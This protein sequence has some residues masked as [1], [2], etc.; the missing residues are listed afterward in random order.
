MFVPSYQ[1]RNVLNVYCKQLRHNLTSEKNKKEPAKPPVDQVKLTPEAKR[2]ATIDKVSKEIVDKITRFDS[3][4]KMHD[5]L[6]ERAKGEQPRETEPNEGKDTT[7][8]FNVIDTINE[9]IT[10]KL[11]VEGSGFSVQRLEQLSKD[12]N[13]SKTESWA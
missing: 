4:E 3:L 2:Q 9:K 5:Q 12:E 6:T 7:F 8:V 11:S 10:N 13:D 1:M